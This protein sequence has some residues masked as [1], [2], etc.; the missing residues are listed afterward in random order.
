VFASNGNV[1]AHFFT[2]IVT[3]VTILCK[4]AGILM[5]YV[6]CDGASW[7]RAVW[8]NFGVHGSVAAVRWKVVHPSDSTR[9]VYFI[10]DVPHLVKCTRS[11]MM[12]TG[13]NP[14]NGR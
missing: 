5:N 3:E 4:Q 10:F 7:N 11:Q 14:P 13:F 6:C 8:H 12:T 9:F 1:K 2:K